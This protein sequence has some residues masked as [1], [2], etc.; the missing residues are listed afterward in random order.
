LISWTEKA[1]KTKLAFALAIIL[2]VFGGSSAFAHEIA[3]ASSPNGQVQSAEVQHVDRFRVNRFT[4]DAK[5]VAEREFWIDVSAL[6]GAW[7]FDTIT[8]HQWITNCSSCKEAGGLANGS[9]SM[10]RI[11]AENAALDAGLAV[12]GYE[13][14]KRVHNKYLHPL[15][16]VPILYQAQ[17]HVRDG[18]YNRQHFN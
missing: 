9:R 3:G 13:W 12:L 16:R 6:A 5:P 18:I 4:R 11:M 14:K 7:T 1:V 2:L 10:P 17:E 15:W 8:T